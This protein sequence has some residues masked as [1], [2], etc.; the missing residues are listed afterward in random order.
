MAAS[1]IT[2]TPRSPGVGKDGLDAPAGQLAAA[3]ITAAGKTDS[4]TETEQHRQ[5]GSATYKP[6][7]AVALDPDPAQNWHYGATG[8]A[9][10]YANSGDSYSAQYA[11]LQAPS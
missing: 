5:P 8:I 9:N 6:L 11:G 7:K 10:S 4:R 3:G 2:R 1:S